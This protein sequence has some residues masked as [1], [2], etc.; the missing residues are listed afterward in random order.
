MTA[1]VLLGFSSVQHLDEDGSVTRV[2]AAD[3][4]RSMPISSGGLFPATRGNIQLTRRWSEPLEEYRL[5]VA[6]EGKRLG[7][8]DAKMNMGTLRAILVL[9]GFTVG[10]IQEAAQVA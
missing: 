7:S 8:V 9:L 5:D 1:L 6:N 10:Q 3:V 4:L 2:S